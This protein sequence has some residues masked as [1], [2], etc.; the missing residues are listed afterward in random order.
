[1]SGIGGIGGLGAKPA[2][3][4][5]KSL[6]M[7]TILKGIEFVQSQPWIIALVTGL[8]NKLKGN[9]V[10][11]KAEDRGEFGNVDGL[12]D[13]KIDIGTK[14]PV[15]PTPPQELGYTSAKLV[16]KMAQFNRELFPGMYD[17]NAGR[18]KDGLYKR[19]EI[20]AA[21]SGNGAFN[22]RTKI[23]FDTTPF[24]GANPVLE[25]EG[26]ADGILWQPVYNIQGPNGLSVVRDGGPDLIPPDDGRVQLVEGP[27]TAHVGV[28]NWRV[29]NGFG[30]QINVG[31]DEG[32]YR[33]WVDYP[34]LGLRT[35][36]ITFKVS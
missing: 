9:K 21:L 20:S 36:D 4:S 27:G 26:A 30:L 6:D 25:A 8:F 12:P 23:W 5:A 15:L 7:N 13:D 19:D 33:V 24:K 31:E 11:Q 34:Q 14:P 16:V 3:P 32:D 10:K 29:T 17:V 2:A 18:N 1:M 28:T 22:R 35:N